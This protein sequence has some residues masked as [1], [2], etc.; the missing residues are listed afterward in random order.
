MFQI[1]NIG[2]KTILIKP[3]IPSNLPWILCNLV[4]FFYRV[5]SFVIPFQ[6]FWNFG[7]AENVHMTKVFIL[8]I[9]PGMFNW[10]LKG[11]EQIL[12]RMHLD[13]YKS[14]D[15]Y[16]TLFM[17]PNYYSYLYGKHCYEFPSCMCFG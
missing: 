8:P 13:L 9:E 17:Y 12:C 3:I 2:H 10:T 1:Q 15:K 11:M 16:I 7:I 6:W 4:T 14:N 5:F